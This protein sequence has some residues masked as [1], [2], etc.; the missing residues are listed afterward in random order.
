MKSGKKLGET[1]TTK[2]IVGLGFGVS[3]F[4]LVSKP[5]KKKIRGQRRRGEKGKKRGES[6]GKLVKYSF[7]I[8]GMT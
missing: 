6:S 1:S 4:K 2:A 5:V 7:G 8:G 3:S